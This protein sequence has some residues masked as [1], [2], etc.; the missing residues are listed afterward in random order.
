M[1]VSKFPILARR[2]QGFCHCSYYYFLKFFLFVILLH[3][4]VELWP[5]HV[6]SA[7]SL[8]CI[9]DQHS[10]NFRSLVL[11]ALKSP[12]IYYHVHFNVFL[13]CSMLN[14]YRDFPFCFCECCI[15][16]CSAHEQIKPSPNQPV[17]LDLWGAFTLEG[18]GLLSK[19]L[20][21]LMAV[22]QITLTP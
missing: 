4:I 2:V 16:L 21:G 20:K 17:A 12:V 5:P 18:K 7:R 11:A 1:Y 14:P 8:F 10:P 6:W 3:H 15:I 19:M 13:G 22:Y 9:C